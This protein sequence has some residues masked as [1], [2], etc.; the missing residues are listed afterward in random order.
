MKINIVVYFALG[1]PFLSC[2]QQLFEV[3]E[4]LLATYSLKASEYHLE[5]V[6]VVSGATSSDVMQFRRVAK[7]GSF[8]VINNISDIDSLVQCQILGDTIVARVRGKDWIESIEDKLIKFP[9]D[10]TWTPERFPARQK[11]RKRK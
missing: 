5:V 1:L 2:G 3:E 7:N 10:M 9:V 4:E 8:Y 11:G 6:N